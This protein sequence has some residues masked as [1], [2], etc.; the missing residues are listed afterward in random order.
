MTHGYRNIASRLLSVFALAAVLA[1]PALASDPP[2]TIAR[3]TMGPVEMQGIRL[4]N[5]GLVDGRIYRGEQP[6][7]NDYAALKALG[8]TTIV[9]LRGDSEDY[10]RSR[11]EAAGLKYVNIPM[12]PKKTPTDAEAARFLEVVDS[13]A[14]ESLYVHCAGGRHRTGAMVAIYRMAKNG[15]TVDRAYDE[16]KAY[17]Y[18]TRWGHGGYKEYVF[19]YFKRMSEN[20]A[21]VPVAYVKQ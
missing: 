4:E 15:W 14:G 9:D 2:I 21:S 13:S 18:Y 12:K 3:D 16:M 19:D 11:A 1:V 17:D 6:G 20:P 10:A 5:F 7:E 8:I